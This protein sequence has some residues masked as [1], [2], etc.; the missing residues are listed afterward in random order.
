MKRGFPNWWYPEP[1]DSLIAPE[2]FK[3]PETPKE[4]VYSKLFVSSVNLA[5]IHLVNFQL[6][7]SR[8]VHLD[9]AVLWA[10]LTRP[11]SSAPVGSDMK[12]LIN[13]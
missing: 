5:T 11:P 2:M 6:L 1:V 3:I 13:W 7:D 12:Q 9:F 10:A 4:I 8:S